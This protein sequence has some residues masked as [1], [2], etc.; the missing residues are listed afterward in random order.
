MAERGGLGPTPLTRAFAEAGRLT[1]GRLLHLD[2]RGLVA[3]VTAL[4]DEHADSPAVVRA[5]GLVRWASLF[6]RNL[7]MTLY[8]G[9][10]WA[11]LHILALVV[12]GAVT[13][14][15]GIPSRAAIVVDLFP[16]LMFGVALVRLAVTTTRVRRI[17]SLR[18]PDPAEP[19]LVNPPPRPLLWRLLEPTDLDLLLAL[20]TVGVAELLA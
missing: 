8:W 9:A 13:P 15:G 17:G 5:S 2:L 3:R 18:R 19:R 10:L 6:V 4:A 1:L 16:G 12:A 20:L 7:E 11:I 14:H